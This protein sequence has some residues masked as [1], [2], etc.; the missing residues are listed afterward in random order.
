M[1]L[2]QR[3]DLL[4]ISLDAIKN[5]VKLNIFSNVQIPA[6]CITTIPTKLTVRCFTTTPCILE[7]I[8]D[9]IITIQTLN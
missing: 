7:V 8:E 9:E 3:T 2:H 6:C 5:T 1:F 4:I